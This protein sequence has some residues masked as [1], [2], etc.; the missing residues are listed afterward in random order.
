MDQGKVEA[1]KN[2]PLP[3]SIKEL[4][5]F[6]G[7]AYFYRKLISNFL[8]ELITDHRNLE[9]LQKSRRLTP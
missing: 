6:L 4:Q 1:V 8:F 7:F 3:T 5:Q 9:Y 2:W